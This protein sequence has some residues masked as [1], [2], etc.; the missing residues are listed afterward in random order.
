MIMMKMMMIVIEIMK[1]I[2]FKSDNNLVLPVNLRFCLG[3]AI[4]R[5]KEAAVT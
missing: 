3:S 1:V 5:L 2:T 4:H